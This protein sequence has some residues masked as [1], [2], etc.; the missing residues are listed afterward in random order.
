MKN[1]ASDDRAGQEKRPWW[2]FFPAI[3]VIESVN[4]P[5]ETPSNA[6]GRDIEIVQETDA[7][8]HAPS[9]ASEATDTLLGPA[10]QNGVEVDPEMEH[11]KA[12]TSPPPYETPKLVA[13]IVKSFIGSGVRYHPMSASIR[14]M[15]YTPA[16]LVLAQSL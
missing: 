10:T 3:S 5:A 8:V 6:N 4:T 7:L 9:D 15:R 14:L 2:S 1:R 16:G 12:P 13:T 11:I